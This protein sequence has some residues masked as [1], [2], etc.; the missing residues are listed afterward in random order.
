VSQTIFSSIQ[1]AK[2]YTVVFDTTPDNARIEQMS[3]I[4]IFVEI[5]R[6]SVQIEEAF[7]D[8]NSLGVET[9]DIITGNKTYKQGQDGLNLKAAGVSLIPIKQQ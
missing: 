3:R 6:D 8:F 7:M 1:K 5:Q 4:V 2:F 9:V